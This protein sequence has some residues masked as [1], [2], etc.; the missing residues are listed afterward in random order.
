MKRFTAA[1]STILVAS[2]LMVASMPTHAFL[3][4]VINQVVKEVSKAA[5]VKI[6]ID[7]WNHSAVPVKVVMDG[8]R[9][10]RVIA[11]G[12]KATFGNANL[13]DMPTFHFHNPANGQQ[14]GSKRVKQTG[15][16]TIEWRA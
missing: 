8:G 14:L 6:H 13:G 12:H 5:K 1:T 11:S 16:S 10:E 4:K 9:E 2:T 15:N 7:V 3:D